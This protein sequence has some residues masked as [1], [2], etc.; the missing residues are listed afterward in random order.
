[1]V[2]YYREHGFPYPKLTLDE[3][4]KEHNLICATDPNTIV[5]D[6]KITLFNSV[7]SV[8]VKHFSPHFF[9]VKSGTEDHKPSVLEAFEDDKLLDKVIY[10]RLSQNM[11]LSGNM[12]RQG[13]INSNIGYRA[14]SFNV[15]SAK[16]IYSKYVPENGVIYD[17][18]MGFGQRL[19]GALSLPYHITYVGTDPLTKSVEGNKKMFNMIKENVPFLNKNVDLF[20]LGSEDFCDQQ[21]INKVDVAFSSPP[22]FNLEIFEKDEK[23]SYYNKSYVDFIN[24]WW[25]KTV[26]NIKLLLKNEGLFIINIKDWVNGFYLSKDML[27]VAYENNFELQETLHYQLTKNLTFKNKNGS[28]K[29]EPIYVLK[30][31]S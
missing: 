10:N 6:N 30:K 24:N 27:G 1:M 13:I 21:Y 26:K 9:E 15:L 4:V 19:L 12:L 3:I 7:G 20:N 2:S 23:Q 16:Y 14:S 31:K 17:Y 28:H 18:S 5:K 11:S 22:Y 8:L 29:Y 25:R